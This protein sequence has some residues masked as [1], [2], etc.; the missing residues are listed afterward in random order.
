MN[1]R[2]ICLLTL[3][4]ITFGFNLFAGSTSL[5]Y[6]LS[7]YYDSNIL[8]L[9]AEEKDNFMAGT[10]PEKY[11]INSIDSYCLGNRVEFSFKSYINRHTHIDKFIFKSKNYLNNSIK[12]NIYLGFKAKQYLSSGFNFFGS[13]YYFTDIY[14]DQFNS[15]IEP[16]T[17]YRDFSYSKDVIGSGL[18]IDLM[19][20]LQIGADVTYEMQFYNKYFKYYDCDEMRYRF[21]LE[22]SYGEYWTKFR[23]DYTISD[24]Y[25]REQVSTKHN[26]PIYKIPDGSYE[27]DTYKFYLDFPLIIFTSSKGLELRYEFEYEHRFY[28]SD[29]DEENDPLHFGR[30]DKC[31]NHHLQLDLS[32]YNFLIFNVFYEYDSRNSHAPAQ[33]L[34]SKEKDF[35][36]YL[37]GVMLKLDF[38]YI[39]D[40][41]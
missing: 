22:P 33:E 17:I 19:Q 34:V 40:L 31:Y 1:K 32:L 5:D 14:L 8:R 39:E 23:Y 36:K 18:E 10:N 16:A 6:D 20:G 13:Y 29:L 3:F 28:R 2:R 24:A 9:S 7:F 21:W 35:K 15:I 12:D 25:D 4:L 30:E 41:F 11:D 26:I 27:S 38:N 37:Y